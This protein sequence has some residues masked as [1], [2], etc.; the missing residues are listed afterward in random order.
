VS[1]DSLHRLVTSVAETELYHSRVAL[2][3][4]AM[5]LL[6]NQGTEEVGEKAGNFVVDGQYIQRVSCELCN[7][8][9]TRNRHS[10]QC[11]MLYVCK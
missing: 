5:F 11:C 7:C 6:E 1:Y 9:E 2:E 10:C 3:R 4:L 8:C